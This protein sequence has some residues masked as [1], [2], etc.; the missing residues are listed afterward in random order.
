M[1]EVRF[2]GN[3]AD[4]SETSSGGEAAHVAEA[5]MALADVGLDMT[6]CSW[7][8][9]VVRATAPVSHTRSLRQFISRVLRFLGR[10]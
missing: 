1:F 9:I 8:D 5:R 4:F 2:D 7:D 3:H 6:K 10:G